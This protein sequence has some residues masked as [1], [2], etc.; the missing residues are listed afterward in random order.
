VHD[1]PNEEELGKALPENVIRQLD[2]HLDLLGPTGR[3]GPLTAAA[4]QLM[5]Q[6]IY[7]ILRDTGRRPGEVVSLRLGCVEVIDGQHNLIYDNHKA[8]RMRRRLPITTDTTQVIT[9]WQR[10]RTQLSTPDSQRQWLFPSPLLRAHQSR[11]HLTSASV[12]RTFKGWVGRIGTIDSELLGPDGTP[13]P[14]DPSLITPYALR[15]SYAQRHADA[16]VPVDVLKELMDHAAVS[17][18]MGYYS[19]GL[20][21]KQQAIRMVGAL[22]VDAT[23]NP[24]PFTSPTAYQQASVSV[25]FGNCT[26]PSNVK[27]GGGACPIRF[28]CAGCGFYRPDPSYLPALEQQI[29]GLRTDRETAEAIGAATYVIDNLTAEIDAFTRVAEQMRHRLAELTSSERDEI[30]HASKLLR[31]ARASRQL[32]VITNPPPHGAAG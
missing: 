17:T 6:T 8:G 1:D 16:G 28:Q 15:H 26:E 2:A 10:H 30:E 7:R 21:R 14:F 25:P 5:H 9:S 32:P 22:A 3:G 4:L 13:A 27:A 24:A 23:G 20:K 12:G 19:V 29:A 31:R 11:G 18:T